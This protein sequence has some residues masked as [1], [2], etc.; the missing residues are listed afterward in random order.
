M[1]SGVRIVEVGPRDGFQPIASFIPTET[2]FR[3]VA[4]L[5]AA[6][7]TDIEIG[8]FASAQAVPQLADTP[9]LLDLAKGLSG[10]TPRVLV[11]T[12]GYGMK[13]LAAGADF[14]AFV[15]SVSES[16]NRSNVRRSPS[17]SAE[18][19]LRLA[20]AVPP[21]TRL[22]LNLATAFDCPF[23]GR[24]EPGAVYALLE[25]LIGAFPQAEIGLCDTTG[26]ADPRHVAS[27]FDTVRREFGEELAWVFHGHDTYGLGAANVFAAYEH[28]VRIF[29]AAFAGLGGC[30]YAPGATGNVATEDVVFLFEQMGV[31]TSCDL[32]RLAAVA[33]DGAALPGAQPGGRVRT[34]LAARCALDPAAVGP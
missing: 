34:A 15:L 26:R 31:A 13:A 22:R 2:K 11:P 8:S 5:H 16:H 12:L 9:A 23:E 6:G 4:A 28:G 20:E 18:E 30:P 1:N 10:L 19:Y 29:D 21:G 27:L 25:R 24:T 32:G 14:L 3:L 33:E 7:L 17:D